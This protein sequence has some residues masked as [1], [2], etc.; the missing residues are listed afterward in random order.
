MRFVFVFIPQITIP[1]RSALSL[2]ALFKPSPIYLKLEID[3]DTVSLVLRFTTF[4]DFGVVVVLFRYLAL[5]LQVCVCL[6]TQYS[7]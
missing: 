3:Q 4:V 1:F 2:T 6:C 7:Y 5:V